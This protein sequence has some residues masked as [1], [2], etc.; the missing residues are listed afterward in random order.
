MT[1]IY[2]MYRV[3]LIY[4]IIVNPVFV[5]VVTFF[6]HLETYLFSRV[7]NITMLT[8]YFSVDKFTSNRSISFHQ[9]T[10]LLNSVSP[11]SYF[12]P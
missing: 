4:I 5:V 1:C 12:Y 3:K 8:F 7:S 10:R 2:I 9:G 6:Y 11:V